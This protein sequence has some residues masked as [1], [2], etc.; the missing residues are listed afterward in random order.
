MAIGRILL[1]LL[2]SFFN[3][4]IAL[5]KSGIGNLVLTVYRLKRFQIMQC[6]NNIRIFIQVKVNMPLCES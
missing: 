3:V 6:A 5:F 4:S 1:T 2:I